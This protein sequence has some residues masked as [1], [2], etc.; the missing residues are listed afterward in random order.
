MLRERRSG[1][2]APGSEKKSTEIFSLVSK[3]AYSLYREDIEGINNKAILM[4]TEIRK[5][6]TKILCFIS[7]NENKRKKCGYL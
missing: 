2:F 6:F 5:D 4:A 7:H 3:F 1:T